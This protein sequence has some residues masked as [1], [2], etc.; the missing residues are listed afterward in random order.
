[1]AVSPDGRWIAFISVESGTPE[2]FVHPFPN[3]G[4]AR[5]QISTDGGVEPVWAHSGQEIFYRSLDEQLISVA[6]SSGDT[7]VVGETRA[8]FAD[9]FVRNLASPFNDVAPD[10][11]RF[12][13]IRDA[14]GDDLGQIV[15]VE[16]F[17]E[18][19]KER[20]SN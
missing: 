13:M 4:D 7:F 15:I 2:V 10:D 19:L 1:M 16:N 20:V 8:L 18:E 14:A 11:Q 5:W 6:V 3:I 9:T 12:V 17:S